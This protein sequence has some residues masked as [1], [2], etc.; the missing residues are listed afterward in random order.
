MNTAPAHLEAPLK[1][2]AC[3]CAQV[4]LLLGA[5]LVGCGSAG[6]ASTSAPTGASGAGDVPRASG[7]GSAGCSSAGRAAAIPVCESAATAASSDAAGGPGGS[8][9]GGTVAAGSGAAGPGA[10][11]NAT[12]ASAGRGGGQAGA[13][14]TGG[15]PAAGAAANGGNVASYYMGADVTDQEYAPAEVRERLLDSMIEHGFNA[16]RLRTFVDPRAAD[17]YDK[18]NGYAD[19]AHTIDFGKQIKARGMFLSVDF[20]YSDNWA[21]PGK[22]CVPIAWQR[23]NTIAELASALGDYTRDAITQLVAANARPDLVQV[24][25]EITPGMLLHRC[26]EGGLPTGDNPVRGSIEHWTDL[27]ALLKA[28]VDAVRE[29]DPSISISLHIDR[30]GDKTSDTPGSA[31]ELSIDWLS[32]ATKYVRIDA[33]GESCYQRYQGDPA[34]PERSQATWRAT[35]GGLAQRFP[36]IKLFAAEYGPAQREIND[37]LYELPKRQGLGTFNWQPTTEG[38]WNRGHDLWRRSGD[39]YSEQPDLQRYKQMKVDFADRL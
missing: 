20:H 9:S 23:Y 25:N 5:W 14:G 26:D 6:G 35:L 24:G 7:Q 21:D 1:A 22:Q 3:V 12:A 36:E 33:F 38:D 10:G 15:M 11:R 17:G 13:A 37:V 16:I 39:M 8:P 30:G 18:V 27:G 4:S 2:I 34:S 32:E 19:L 31:L 29:V 28:G